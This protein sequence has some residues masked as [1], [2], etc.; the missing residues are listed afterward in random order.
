[1]VTIKWLDSY[2]T[3]VALF[4]K[5]HHRIV[6]LINT[7]LAAILE[8]KGKEVFEKVCE[9][10]LTYAQYHFAHEEKAMALVHYPGIEEHLADHQWL[11]QEA[12]KFQE[13]IKSNFPEGTKEMYVF[14]RQW[15]VDHIQIVDKQ[16]SSYL[17]DL[18]ETNI[19]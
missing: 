6:E 16:Y 8:K 19:L 3:G 7:M 17:I 10:I 9:D 4:D 11:K 15:L 14:L 12:E 1:M 13:I 5:E 2:N 18:E